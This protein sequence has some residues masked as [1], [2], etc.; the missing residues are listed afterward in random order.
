VC[1]TLPGILEDLKDWMCFIE[2]N[3]LKSVLSMVK[4]NAMKK[5]KF[6]TISERNLVLERSMKNDYQ[7]QKRGRY[8]RG[9][10]PVSVW[11]A[12]APRPSCVIE[13]PRLSPLTNEVILWNN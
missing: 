6:V 2:N 1:V 5:G 11:V 13:E 12:L 9:L 4:L 3:I 10:F 7:A 8:G